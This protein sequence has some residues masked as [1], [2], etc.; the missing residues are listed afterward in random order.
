MFADPAINTAK[1]SLIYSTHYYQI[2]DFGDRTDNIDILKRDGASISIK[3]LSAD[4]HLRTDIARSQ[5]FD[6]NAFGT[7]TCYDRLM[8]IRN[9]LRSK[10]G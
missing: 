6:Q 8:Q 1:A 9:Y 2:L 3:N 7:L 10:K 4:F 5:W